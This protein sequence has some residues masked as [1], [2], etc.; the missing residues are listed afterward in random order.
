MPLSSIRPAR[1]ALRAM[2]DTVNIRSFFLTALCLKGWVDAKMARRMPSKEVMLDLKNLKL[3]VDVSRVELISYWETWH[4]H[5]YDSIAIDG[6][7]CVVDVGANIGAFSLY[8]AMVKHAESVI[9]FEP[10]PFVFPRL[11]KNVKN[12]GSMNVRTVNAA[13]GDKQGTLSFSEGQMSAN[14]RVCESGS[15]KVPC[16]TLDAE[17]SDV[18]SIDILKIDTEG[19]ETNVLRGA[20]ETLKKTKR[21]ALELHYPEERQ[22][23]ESILFP[24]KFSLMTIHNDLVFYHRTAL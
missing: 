6:P 4:E 23:I 9:A 8:Q 20:S 10:S 14:S 24:L 1:R 2:T 18:P 19:Y 13:V 5:C 3:C 17:L 15:L 21:I 12:N 7:R 16:V 11:V 22:E